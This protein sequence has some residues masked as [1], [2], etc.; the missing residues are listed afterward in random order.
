MDEANR[1]I[2][3][4]VNRLPQ[5]VNPENAGRNLANQAVRTVSFKPY[6][7]PAA[8]QQMAVSNSNRRDDI[9]RGFIVRL[10]EIFQ[11]ENNNRPRPRG[12]N[13]NGVLNSIQSRKAFN[14]NFTRV[15]EGPNG[16]KMLARL[17]IKVPNVY[18][19]EKFKNSVNNYPTNKLEQIRN[20]PQATKAELIKFVMYAYYDTR[21]NKK[22]KGFFHRAYAKLTT[23]DPSNT[24][25][26]PPVTLYKFL[27]RLNKP[28]I[29][30]FLRLIEW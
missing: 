15:V 26:I 13:Y 11:N 1:W 22:Q 17:E 14:K 23:R 12:P 6:L 21:T 28:T 9:L 16:Q 7:M 5:N 27:Y 8:Y 3:N 4:A 19:N 18:A 2:R 30:K 24:R 25:E 20:D 29:R 10:R